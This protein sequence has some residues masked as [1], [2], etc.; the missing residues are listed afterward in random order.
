MRRIFHSDAYEEPFSRDGYVVIP[1]LEPAS[2]RALEEIYARVPQGSDSTFYTSHWNRDEAYR[3]NLNALIKPLMDGCIT[4]LMQ[5]YK[6]VLSYFLVKHPGMAGEVF[7]HQDWSVLDESI[8]RG[9]TVWCPLVDTD[10][11]NGAFQLVKG[12]H[13]FPPNIRGSHIKPTYDSLA[14][15]VVDHF[16]TEIHLK[17]GEAIFFDHRL[18]HYSPPNFSG[19]SRIAV[20][21]A[22]IPSEA[23]MIHYYQEEAEPGSPVRIYEAGDDFL[24]TFGFGDKP[25]H[26]HLIGEWG[27]T[28]HFPDREEFE[29]WYK[30]FN[31]DAPVSLP[32]T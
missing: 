15:F 3:K 25:D 2:I 14:Q 5:K 24:L 18:L 26:L 31:P 1:L 9:V 19:Q 27:G 22:L 13:R 8:H 28:R 12:S 21:H 16:L 17:A 23:K 20:G 32:K 10:H 30:T 6:S 7:L 29:N 11:R 4:P